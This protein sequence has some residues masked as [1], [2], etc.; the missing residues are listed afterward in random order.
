MP[1]N[2]TELARRHP[3]QYDSPAPRFFEG[4]LLG[5]GHLGAVINTRPD[6]VAIRLGHNS[7]WDIRVDESNKDKFGTFNE[8]WEKIKT[9]DNLM[10][11]H[12]YHAYHAVTEESYFKKYPRPFPC[13]SIYLFFERRE[14]EL[15]G[16]SLDIS[17][18][19][20]SIR[21]L[22]KAGKD[23]YCEIFVESKTDSADRL[24]VRCVDSDGKPVSLFNRVRIIPETDT[25]SE[26]PTFEPLN[27]SRG[28][29]FIQRLPA[30][31]PPDTEFSEDDKGFAVFADCGACRSGELECRH[32]TNAPFTLYI[33]VVNGNYAEVERHA[34]SLSPSLTEAM[35]LTRSVLSEYWNRSGVRLE[36]E[37]L[38]QIW[39]HNLYFLYCSLDKDSTCPGLFGNFM[40][41]NIGTAWHGD[42]HFNYNVQQIFWASFITNHS[43]QNLPYVRLIEDLLPLSR[44]W[45]K[46]YFETE[47]AY[48]PHC[49][50]PVKMTTFPYPTTDWGWQICETPWAVQG[51]WWQY[52]Y[53]MDK[54]LLRNRLFEPIKQATLF[55][56]RYMLRPDGSG[57]R[58]GDDR[59]HVFPT[60]P[61][62]LYAD[63]ANDWN[64]RRDCLVDLTFIKFLFNAF[65]DAVKILEADEHELVADCLKILE[66]FPLYP[67]HGEPGDDVFVSVWGEDPEVVQNTPNTGMPAFPGEEISFSDSLSPE[68]AERYKTAVRSWRRQRNEGGNELVF[69]NLQGARL[70]VLDLEVFKRQVKYCL[71][72]N[73][74]CTDRVLLSGGRYSDDMDFDFM[75]DMG[76][77]IENFSLPSV[78]SNCLIHGHGDT[79]CL[80]P[81]WKLDK[82]AEFFG[83]R[84]KGAFLIGSACSDGRVEYVDIYSE[85]GGICSLK[86]PWTNKIEHIT[87]SAGESIRLTESKNTS[88]P[89]D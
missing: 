66:K 1:I 70:G 63:F 16:H 67:I 31:C 49:A 61:P 87:L 3:I 33:E 7:I 53:T 15:I 38:E 5:N 27:L 37:F 39:Y 77:W 84:T 76:V 80:F 6:A 52:I 23:Y 83:H 22:D 30:R 26:I 45:A 21:F 34:F 62:E 43:E 86:N 29:G 60:V 56:T 75:S 40:F 9:S 71:R 17:T 74:T 18:G 82:K 14:Y 20:L 59:F 58:W 46:N 32:D 79:V 19:I 54:E 48:F 78:I 13:G 25:E 28:M 24:F 44:E 64:R 69:Y 89:S 36:D 41:R 11:E 8:I 2:G 73:G 35:E 81:N 42:Y 51:L 55:I 57:E 50:Y 4:A 85:K 47:G 68:T 12:W 88:N 65:L 72:P 10:A